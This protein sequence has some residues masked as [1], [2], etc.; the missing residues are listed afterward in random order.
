MC[1]FESLL[2]LAPLHFTSVQ[3]SQFVVFF[4]CFT[5]VALLATN[6]TGSAQVASIFKFCHR[7]VC[8]LF[9]GLLSIPNCFPIF[10]SLLFGNLE[11]NSYGTEKGGVSDLESGMET[12]AFHPRE[13]YLFRVGKICV[14]PSAPLC[15]RFC[16]RYA[17]WGAESK[18]E[19]QSPSKRGLTTSFS[20]AFSQELVQASRQSRL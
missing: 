5:H 11:F 6:M 9:E 3:V 20:L 14:P 8:P 10:L 1:Q 4:S 7:N 17:R 2:S 18:R 16:V 13:M 15:F 12:W 19:T